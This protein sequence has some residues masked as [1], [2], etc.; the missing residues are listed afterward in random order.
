MTRRLSPLF[1][2]V[3]LAWLAAWFWVFSFGFSSSYF[4]YHLA[5]RIPVLFLALASIAVPPLSCSWSISRALKGTLGPVKASVL[6]MVM[7]AAPILVFRVVLAAWVGLARMA[8]GIAFEADEAM[9]NGIVFLFCAAVSLGGFLVVPLVLW[10][11]ALWKRR[12][13]DSKRA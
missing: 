11:L 8:G 3:Y 1:L 7:C 10:G 4:K 5:T 13:R 9:G 12:V 2:G 6:N